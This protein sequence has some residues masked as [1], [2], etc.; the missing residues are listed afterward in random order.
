MDNVVAGIQGTLPYACDVKI[1]A[2]TEERYEINLLETVSRAFMAGIKFNPDKRLVAL[3]RCHAHV[4]L[5]RVVKV[6]KLQSP[7]NKKELQSS[8]GT[9][10][11]KSTSIPN[12]A[13]VT[14]VMKRLLKKCA[15]RLGPVTYNRNSRASKKQSQMLHS[16]H[17]L[18]PAQQL[19]LIQ[20]RHWKVSEL[21]SFQMKDPWDSLAN[22]WLQRKWTTPSSKK[23]SSPYHLPV[24]VGAKSVLLSNTLSSLI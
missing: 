5:N 3:G 9:D 22:H 6:S 16:S 14:H 12:L 21:S 19:S 7:C 18:I 8:L 10:N 2:F 17:A 15:P 20:L 24:H 4:A 13:K 23:N 1:Q 11:F